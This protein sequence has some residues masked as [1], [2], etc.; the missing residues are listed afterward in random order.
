[1]NRIKTKTMNEHHDPRLYP[2][3]KRRSFIRHGFHF[4]VFT[5]DRYDWRSYL[6][7]KVG[8]E[9]PFPLFVT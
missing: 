3:L 4:F 1:M 9:S 2:L 8:G 7:I 6:D 5:F